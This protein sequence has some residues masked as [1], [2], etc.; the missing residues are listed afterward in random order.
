MN[1]SD[2]TPQNLRL[3]FT[4]WLARILLGVLG[5]YLLAYVLNSSLGG[6]WLAPARDG[7]DRFAPQFGGLS[8][9]DAI[10]WQPRSGRCSMGYLDRTGALFIPLIEIDQRFFH[11]THYITDPNYES[12]IRRLT[13]SKVHPVFR[14]EFDDFIRTNKAHAL[15]AGLRLCFIRRSLARAS[16]AHRSAASRV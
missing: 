4:K 8:I 9:T 2:Q 11:K 10:M 6:Y 3:R 13:R 12:W 14:Q 1:N 16:D 5:L 15:D 7:R